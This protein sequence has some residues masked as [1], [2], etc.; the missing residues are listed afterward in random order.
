MVFHNLFPGVSFRVSP[1]TSIHD[2]YHHYN[3]NNNNNNNYNNHSPEQFSPSP[4]IEPQLYQPRPGVFSPN[5][6][7]PPLQLQSTLSVEEEQVRGHQTITSPVFK[8]F[9]HQMTLHAHV[10]RVTRETKF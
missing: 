8:L 3:N 5:A 7:P 1:R 10:C 6:A 9:F 2:H 4:L